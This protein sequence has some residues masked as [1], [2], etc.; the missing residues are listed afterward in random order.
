[1]K[2]SSSVY[3]D[4][5]LLPLLAREFIQL[6]DVGGS[7]ETL[8][9]AWSMFGFLYGTIPTAP[10][11]VIFAS[12]FGIEEEKVWCTWAKMEVHD[13]TYMYIHVVKL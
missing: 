12:K 6:L 11:V 13:C 2:Y 10:T 9:D 1:M 4:R 5:V 7:N 3:L 8:T